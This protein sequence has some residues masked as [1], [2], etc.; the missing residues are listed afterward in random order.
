M[1]RIIT[2]TSGKGGVGKT[3][4]SLNLSLELA[5]LGSRVCLFDADLGLANINILTGIHPEKD[6]GDL[7]EGHVTLEEIIIRNYQGIDIIP[8]S[9]GVEKIA[10]LTREQSQAMIQAFL[11]LEDYDYFVF[12]T[13]AGISP[14]VIAFCLASHEILLVITPEPT[15]LTDGYA[16]LKVLS[17]HRFDRRV[18]VAINQVRK[19]SAAQKAYATFHNTV[20]RFL[21]ITL[22][23]LGIVAADRHVAA[24]VTAQT[25]FVL[26]FPDA[27]ASQCIRSMA[28]RLSDNPGPSP[29]MPLEL[30]WDRCLAFL[31]KKKKQTMPGTV[32]LETTP[33]PAN[34]PAPG[35]LA[36]LDAMETR[37]MDLLQ[38]VQALRAGLK[39][40]NPQNSPN[41]ETSA[42]LEAPPGSQVSHSPVQ[43]PA[44]PA[45]SGKPQPHPGLNPEPVRMKSGE[46]VLDFESWLAAGTSSR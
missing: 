15:S 37:L 7:I 2:V 11:G 16:L 33:P 44:P 21:P 18:H 12:D 36:R 4:I 46:F 19:A 27:K 43:A 30:F 13:S 39:P 24:A 45:A 6:L 1:A 17:T 28:R 22:T 34:E 23:P 38:D 5:A 41:A 31:N 8:G 14:A 29:S 10:D 20:T 35:I 26:M 9:S 25:P 40:Q 32:G 3:S 42:P